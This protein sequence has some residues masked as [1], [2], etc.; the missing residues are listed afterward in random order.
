MAMRLILV[1]HAKSDW[2]DPMLDDHDRPLNPRGRDAAVRV[3]R[4]LAQAGA[5]PGE[6]LVSSA[7]RTRETWARMAPLLPGAPEPRVIDALYHA[8]PEVM[9]R[10]LQGARAPVVLMLGHNPG[11]GAFARWMLGRAPG[12]PRF[13]DYPTCATLVARFPAARWSDVAPATGAAEAFVVPR[14]LPE[15]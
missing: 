4:W 11:I 9:L 1:R 15:G 7:L 13:H 8:S 2:D 12:H 10:A 6:A 14:E 5:L 3:G